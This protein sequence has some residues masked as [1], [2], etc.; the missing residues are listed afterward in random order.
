MRAWQLTTALLVLREVHSTHF[1]LLVNTFF[2]VIFKR[3]N[4][5][6]LKPYSALIQCPACLEEAHSTRI[7]I[8]VNSFLQVFSTTLILFNS[9][10]I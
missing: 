3:L 2:K 8:P 5:V 4:Q 9:R 6:K 1:Q 7:Q 10:A